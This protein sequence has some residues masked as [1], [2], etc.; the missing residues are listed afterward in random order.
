ML[1]RSLRPGLLKCLVFQ[2]WQLIFKINLNELWLF[3]TSGVDHQCDSNSETTYSVLAAVVRE[4]SSK[5]VSE[6]GTEGHQEADKHTEGSWL[7]TALEDKEMKVQGAGGTEGRW[8]SAPT[9]QNPVIGRQGDR[10]ISS[11]TVA[12]F[13]KG[14]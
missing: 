6:A 8:R 1:K 5:E 2:W 11:F 12:E 14:Q 13:E 4:G 7:G 9:T 10:E 3:A